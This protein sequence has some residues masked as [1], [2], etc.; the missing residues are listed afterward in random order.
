[1]AKMRSNASLK[2]NGRVGAFTFYTSEGRQISRVSENSSNY[3][4]SA[5]RTKNQQSRRVRWAN[6]VNFYKLSK[7]W[8]YYAFEN[9]KRGVSDYNKFMSININ[10][11]VVALTREQAASGGCVVEPFQVTE[12]SLMP[13]QVEHVGNQWK[14]NIKT[15]LVEI[16]NNT[17]IGEFTKSVLSLNTWLHENMQISFISYQQTVSI[18]NIPRV[19]CTAYE[20]TLKSNS[21]QLLRDYLPEFCSNIVDDSLGTNDNISIGAFTYVLSETVEGKTLVS[22]QRLINNN[23]EAIESYSTNDQINAAIKSYGESST[24]FLMSGSEPT[25]A[26]EKETFIPYIYINSIEYRPSDTTISIPTDIPLRI[27][28][29][30]PWKVTEITSMTLYTISSTTNY[31]EETNLTDITYNSDSIQVKVSPKSGTKFNGPYLRF[32]T[33]VIDGVTYRFGN[34]QYP[35]DSGDGPSGE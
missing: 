22:T 15:S 28:I 24:K 3:G 18:Y 1:M 8:M 32:M 7:N 34:G 25:T 29:A 23:L 5:T 9:K 33:M 35:V 21:N 13:V 20:V 27:E 16:T 10:G 30:T 12:G 14:T 31:T 17:T 11:S 6:L 19:I 2:L 4:K 26:T